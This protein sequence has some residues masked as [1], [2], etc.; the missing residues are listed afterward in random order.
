MLSRIKNFFLNKE[1][2]I[3]KTD[4]SEK[5]TAPRFAV[6]IPT[7]YVHPQT[8]EVAYAHTHDISD[9]GLGLVTNYELPT[10]TPIDLKLI[11]MDNGEEIRVKG[12]VLWS[13]LDQENEFR[14]GIK[15]QDCTIKAIPLTLRAIQ[16]N[17]Q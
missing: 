2:A 15:L 13:R 7:N 1:A 14:S 5:R 17:L 6:S 3:D 12:Q 10:G 4:F 9:I 11:M 16:A 8:N